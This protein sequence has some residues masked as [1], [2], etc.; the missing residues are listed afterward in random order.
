MN[1]RRSR[2]AFH[3][4]FNFC[5]LGSHICRVIVCTLLP[6]G[7]FGIGVTPLWF[8]RFFF[9]IAITHRFK[10]ACKVYLV[11]IHFLNLVHPNDVNCFL[12]F[13][14]E[15][16]SRLRTDI[17]SIITAAIPSS[18]QSTVEIRLIIRIICIIVHLH[19]DNINPI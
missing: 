13:Q 2:N 11:G 7:F 14:V 18:C 12:G 17:L 1:M 6:V 15:D 19:R 9:R 4:S 8:F 10:K 3:S 16:W 5:G